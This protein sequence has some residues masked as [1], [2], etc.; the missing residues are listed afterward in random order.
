MTL[1]RIQARIIQRIKE[2]EGLPGSIPDDLRMKAMIELRALRLLN[3]Q[4]QVCQHTYILILYKTVFEIIDAGEPFLPKGTSPHSG[5]S[6]NFS[7]AG[8]GV[9]LSSK[10]KTGGTLS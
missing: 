9:L 2:L 6:L 1:V 4:K 3:F 5:F 10:G 8:K 7:S